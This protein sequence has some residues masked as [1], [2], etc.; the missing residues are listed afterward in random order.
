MHV[1]GIL[2]GPF[3]NPGPAAR[4]DPETPPA[5][6]HYSEKTTNQKIHNCTACQH[7]VTMLAV[8]PKRPKNSAPAAL[9][10]SVSL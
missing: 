1:F 8:H 3:L 7:Q 10:A 4:N 9:N 6:H 2:F 5:V